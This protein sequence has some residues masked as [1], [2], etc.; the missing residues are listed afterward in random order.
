[1]AS[2]WR[3][4]VVGLCPVEC[5]ERG[6]YPIEVAAHNGSGGV[7]EGQ[8]NK[9]DAVGGLIE[10]LRNRGNTL[11]AVGSRIDNRLGAVDFLPRRV[12][13]ADAGMEFCSVRVGAVDDHDG[14]IVVRVLNMQRLTGF[15]NG[16]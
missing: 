6:G 14:E 15:V 4:R 3:V 11:C 13:H 9:Q 1:M 12:V 2:G 10:L 16:E 8:V 5:C 7:S